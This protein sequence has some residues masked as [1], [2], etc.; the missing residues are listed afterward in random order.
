MSRPDVKRMGELAFQQMEKVNAEVFALTY[1]SL[2]TQLLKDMEYVGEINTQLEKMG[3]SIGVRLV[4]ELFAKS[5]VRSC[6]DFRET[7]EVIAKVGLMMFLGV[8][9]EVV[10]W[11]NEGTKCSILLRDNPLEEFVELPSS[12]NKLHYSNILCGVIRGGLEQ[13][14]MKVACYFVRDTLKG[15]AV[16]EIRLE[17]LEMTREEFI[18]DDDS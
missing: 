17:L 10:N 13:T 5:G 12:L 2:V 3:Y 1:G 14:R 18:D 9:G 15:D 6:S 11:N 7:A 16:S 4:D 8:K